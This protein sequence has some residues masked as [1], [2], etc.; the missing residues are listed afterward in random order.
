MSKFIEVFERTEIKYLLSYKQFTAIKAFL[1][2]YARVDKYGKT[3]IH[4][5]YFDTQDYKLIRTS[6]EKPV[7]KEKLRLRTYEDTNDFTNSFIEIKKKYKGIVY[8]RRVSGIYRKAYEYLVKG[9]SPLDDSQISRE[10][11][12]FRQMYE[13]LRPAMTI[14]YDRIAMAGITDPNFRVTFDTNIQWSTEETDLRYEGWGEQVLK[15][16][17]YLMEIKVAES[18][19]MPIAQKLS[20]LGIFPTSFSKYGKAYTDMIS[21]QARAHRT[22]PTVTPEYEREVAYA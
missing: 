19:P 11:E 6:L 8:K 7:Y 5:I 12:G 14:S 9:G 16:G 21:S 10:I 13:G 4:N 20:E 1:E 18:M 2:N 3:R 22:E 15:E 17:Q